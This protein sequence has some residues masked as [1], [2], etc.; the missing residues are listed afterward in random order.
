MV[1]G[2][3]A[4]A[5]YWDVGGSGEAGGGIEVDPTP[6]P[7][8]EPLPNLVGDTGGGGLGWGGVSSYMPPLREAMP[9]A[10]PVDYSDPKYDAVA[11]GGMVMGPAEAPAV[12][13]PWPWSGGLG[14]MVFGAVESVLPGEQKSWYDVA[15]VVE[16]GG[17]FDL[18]PGPGTGFPLA[19]V[20][21]PVL[22]AGFD[23]LKM[24]PML[25][26]VMSMR[27]RD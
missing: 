11:G 18:T 25:L 27:N 10:E 3:E 9:A 15:P 4:T 21:P 17:K 14:N 12:E 1:M 13:G 5:A 19:A 2:R 23:I 20:V 6:Q 26:L 22:G 16:G 8:R 24:L 7:E